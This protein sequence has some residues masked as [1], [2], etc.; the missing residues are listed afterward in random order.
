[1]KIMKMCNTI[2]E[3]GRDSIENGSI[4]QQQSSTHRLGECEGHD[5][6]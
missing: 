5:D 4:S 1:M 3:N 6:G 2:T